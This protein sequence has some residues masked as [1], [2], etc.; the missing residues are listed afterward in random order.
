MAEEEQKTEEGQAAEG[1]EDAVKKKGEPA[2]SGLNPKLVYGVLILNVLLVGVVAALVA[3]TF[4]QK[5]SA[6]SLGDIQEQ[7]GHGAGE[8]AAGGGEKPSGDKDKKEDPSK[9]FITESFTVNLSDSKGS[10]F[11]K[12][13]VVIEAGD[14][15]VRAE[16]ERIL[17]KIRDFIVVVLSSKTYDQIAS[18]DGRDFLREE[19][20][21]KINGYLTRGQIKDI[22]FTQF[23]VQ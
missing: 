9:L 11:A 22:Y 10:H 7:A 14:D 5:K 18:V 12:V 21:N 19:I 3:M 13:D 8:H 6:V 16:I 15:S 4:M 2:A 20:R 23:I 17:P 1:G